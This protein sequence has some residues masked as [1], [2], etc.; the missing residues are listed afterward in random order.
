M[1]ALRHR[2]TA[3]FE[4]RS[5]LVVSTLPLP[6]INEMPARLAG[7]ITQARITATQVLVPDRLEGLTDTQR[8]DLALV[9]I[10]PVRLPQALDA[11]RVHKPRVVLLLPSNLASRDPM[12]D[13]VYARSWARIN[14]CLVLGPRAFGIQ[15]PHL[16]INLS[17]E[18]QMALAGRVA[19]VSQSRSITSALMDWAED[20]SLGFSAIVSVGD[21]AVI[22]V[23]EVLE[24]LAMD[25]RTDSIA[26][27][28]EHTP[29]SRRFTSA[30]HAVAAV[31][32]VVVLKVGGQRQQGEAHEAVFNALMRR[33]GAVRI[34]YFVQ[35]F[36]ALKVL[37]YTRR[38]KGRRIAL[39]SN[40]NGAAQMAL[41]VLG[42]DAAV[43]CPELS[44]STQRA[45]D[46]LLA[47]GDQ[48]Q[49][50]VVTYVP[51]TPMR[52]DS[53]ISTLLDDKDIDGVLVLLTPDPLA[54]MPAVSRELAMLSASARKPIIT[55]LIGDADMR[56]LRHLLDGVGTPAFR[57]PDTA[58]NAF[59]LLARYHYNQHLSQQTLPPLPLG[60]LPEVE[61]ARELVR[62]IQSERREASEQECRDLL[63]YFH[64][65]VVDLRVTHDQ[66]DPDPHVP[67][68]GLRFETDD[69]LGP[70][71]V[72]GGADHADWLSSS[73][74]AVEL[75][76]LN[77]YLARQL[78]ERSPL[79][80]KSL[81][82]QLTPLVLTQLLQV[83][84]R[85]SDLMSELPGVRRVVLDPIMAGEN[86][87]YIKSISISLS[88]QSML[89]LP[90][91]A[92]YRHMAIH[93]YPRHMIERRQFKDGQRWTL[94][95][96]RPE[97]AEALQ[98]FMRGLSDES[99]Y[100]RFVSML[101]E[102]TPRMLSRYTRIDY[103]RELALIATVRSPNPDNR[104]HPRD[105]IIGFAHYLRNGDGRG[106]EYALVIGDAWQRRGLGVTLMEA[107]IQAAAEQGLTY[108]DGYVLA[109]NAP[110]Q[111]LMKRL[112]F[113]N[114]A[115]PE[116][117]SMRRVWLDLGETRRS[118]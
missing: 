92:G 58:A 66:G 79:W 90:E 56:P 116:D 11:I 4:P 6:L 80:R 42:S 108:I 31:K 99:R 97:D 45:L 21:E 87:L 55:C 57:T 23:P 20:V 117:P 27:Y 50:P 47:P 70:Y 82:S 30:L 76:P 9:C 109:S 18:P 49:N 46:N 105:E 24:Y 59:D 32:P 33:V 95:P 17:H 14:N 62:Q 43:T 52:I 38:P 98:T 12:E 85:L 113:Q 118:D 15:R 37:V 68:M 61:P 106:A 78:V 54:D 22:D 36:S 110:M 19:L 25:P 65:P 73:Y 5:V 101:R 102:L 40:G 13:M 16:G 84:E 112:G 114:D 48:V 10:E 100:M 88:K 44:P 69:K 26:L 71:A 8:L 41:D 64:V 2:L 34:R 67:P 35:L 51:L 93:P 74:P 28:L 75:P 94:R 86:S 115:D 91:T 104:N 53:V 39:F 96:I 103:D 107:L 63:R 77:R 72:F 83:L 29:A 60:T 3:L 81:S 89:V 1:A 111:A 7:R